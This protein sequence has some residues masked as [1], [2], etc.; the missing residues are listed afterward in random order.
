MHLRNRMILTL[1][2]VSRKVKTPT[3]TVFEFNNPLP[4]PTSS[5]NSEHG[6]PLPIYCDSRLLSPVVSLS[7][8]V[9]DQGSPI[10]SYNAARQSH[11]D[12]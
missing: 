8:R 12:T 2:N 7:E 3:C 10:A 4:D 11:C 5:G 1:A 9:K 6:D